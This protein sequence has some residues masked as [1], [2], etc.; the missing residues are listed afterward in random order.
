MDQPICE[1]AFADP[2]DCSKSFQE[3][4]EKVSF[5]DVFYHQNESYFQCFLIFL[6]SGETK[7]ASPPR[8]G[9]APMTAEEAAALDSDSEEEDLQSFAVQ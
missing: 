7:P 8:P 5:E 1:F 9:G 2:D 6:L 3:T 4:F